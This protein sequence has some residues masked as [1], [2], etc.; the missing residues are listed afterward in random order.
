MQLS[1]Y[2]RRNLHCRGGV[3]KNKCS[4]FKCIR[5]LNPLI[6][7]ATPG[8]VCVSVG[9]G[10]GYSHIGTVRVCHGKATHFWPQHLLK[11]QL[12]RPVQLKNDHP[13]HDLSQKYMF[14]FL[15]IFSSK[16][17]FFHVWASSE[18]SPFSVRGHSLSPLF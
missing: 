5:A 12:F 1:K 13:F 7:P 8:F 4:M 18:R 16:T 15:V 14:L 17:P 3:K 6:F 2:Y 9:G 10:G 11:T